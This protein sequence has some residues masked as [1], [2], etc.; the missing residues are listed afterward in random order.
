[1]PELSQAA[2]TAAVALS[3]AALGA[4]AT[5]VAQVVAKRRDHSTAVTLK[6]MELALRLRETEVERAMTSEVVIFPLEFYMAYIRQCAE[7]S[8]K[9]HLDNATIS[10]L[11]A[12]MEALAKLIMA[13]DGVAL[14]RR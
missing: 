14:P 9:P 3:S 4:L 7:L 8:G 2:L 13:R 1:M 12:D 10:E 5:V 6:V 11:G